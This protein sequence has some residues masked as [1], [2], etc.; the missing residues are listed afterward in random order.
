[1]TISRSL[2]KYRWF[3]LALFRYFPDSHYVKTPG[4]ALRFPPTSG[5]MIEGVFW[6][7]IFPPSSRVLSRV[8]D[9]SCAPTLP[10]E[11]GGASLVILC[12]W[13]EQEG[14]P[15]I[16]YK[17]LEDSSS[18]WELHSH[19]I[20]DAHRDQLLMKMQISLDACVPSTLAS[21]PEQSFVNR[22]CS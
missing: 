11:D 12:A 13:C 5:L 15:A 21:I 9:T 7:V 3:L 22:S 2:S 18:A 10:S 8:A 4:R 16:L 17:T 6:A 19:G 1:M 14:R 20:C